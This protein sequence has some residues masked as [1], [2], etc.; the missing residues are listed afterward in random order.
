MGHKL[1][2]SLV[3]VLVLGVRLEEAICI[4]RASSNRHGI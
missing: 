3:L 4:M 1:L 2:M